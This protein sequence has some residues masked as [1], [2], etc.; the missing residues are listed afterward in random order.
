M[1]K[2]KKKDESGQESTEQIVGFFKGLIEIESKEDKINYKRLKTMLIENL[3]SLLKQ[4]SKL[5]LKEEIE[6]DIQALGSP[7]ERRAFELKLRRLDVSHLNITKHLAN[8]ESDEILK[9]QLL[10]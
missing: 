8:L 4:I 9:R 2:T 10:A 5:K 1:F 7:E 3:I 6:I